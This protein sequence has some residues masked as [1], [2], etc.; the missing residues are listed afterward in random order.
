MGDSIG[1]RDIP[2]TPEDAVQI[3]VV[4]FAVAIDS[5]AVGPFSSEAELFE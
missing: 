1:A 2:F 4:A 5:F 3:H